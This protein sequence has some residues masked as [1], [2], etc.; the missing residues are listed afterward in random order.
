[1][2]GSIPYYLFCARLQCVRHRVRFLKLS[3]QHLYQGA[4]ETQKLQ[5]VVN[6]SITIAQLCLIA[7]PAAP[8]TPQVLQT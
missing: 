2:T 7:M 1:M 4:A 8:P 6:L 5:W 3:L